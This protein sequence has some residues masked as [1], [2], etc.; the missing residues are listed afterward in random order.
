[1]DDIGLVHVYTGDGKGKTTA[2][3]GMCV[4][5]VGH[6]YRALIVQF[7]KTAGTY[8][9]NFLDLPGLDVVASGNDCL[10]FSKDITQADLDRAAEGLELA[11][12]ALRSGRY[13]IV[14]L[15]EVSVAIKFGLVNVNEVVK[16]IGGR[17]Q[18]VE[19]VITGRH[20]PPE[21]LD[22]AD[23]ISEVEAVRHPYQKGITSRKGVDR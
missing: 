20:A 2:A 18:G 23:Y 3:L 4:R 22:M 21:L 7:M 13:R 15:D 10:V 14:V 19:A 5:A 12:E 16:A 17:H 9:E 1:M 11:A 6:G 8:G